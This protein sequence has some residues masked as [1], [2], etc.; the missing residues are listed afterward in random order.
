M[1]EL[2]IPEDQIHNYVLDHV[3][4]LCLGGSND[5]SNLRL[6]PL[7]EA[8]RKD[9]EERRLCTAVARGLIPLE[10]ARKRMEEWR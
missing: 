8:Q 1:R 3:Q 6:Q 4:P 9:R 5:R 7:A 2:Y 10:T